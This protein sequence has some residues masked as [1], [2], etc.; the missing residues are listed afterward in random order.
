ML[1]VAA[2][3]WFEPPGTLHPFAENAS[4]TGPAEL[5]ATFVTDNNCGLLVL[6]E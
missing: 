1:Y 5:L 6:P 3:F 4:K 2:Q